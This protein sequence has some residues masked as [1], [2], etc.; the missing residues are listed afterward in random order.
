MKRLKALIKLEAMPA[1][2]VGIY[3]LIVNLGAIMQQRNTINTIWN[4]YLKC[5]IVKAFNEYYYI[6][7]YSRVFYTPIVM[8]VILHL[9]G[10]GTLVLLSFK[11]DK[12]IETGRFLKSLPY[13]IKER[14]F[15]KVSIGLLTYTVTYLVYVVGSYFSAAS[16]V[17]KYDEIFKVTTLAAIK[18][19]IFAIERVFAPILLAYLIVVAA[20]LFLTMLQYAV[21]HLAGGMIIGVLTL[22]SPFFILFSGYICLKNEQINHILDKI[23]VGLVNIVE[24]IPIYHMDKDTS[25]DMG[26]DYITYYPLRIAAILIGI[27]ITL[28]LIIYFSHK[29]RIEKEDIL[30]P[31]KVVQVIFI[32]GV[33][34]CSGLLMGDLYRVFVYGLFMYSSIDI[35]YMIMA[36][37]CVIGGIIS[38][39]IA[40]IG[41]KIKQGGRA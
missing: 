16:M 11:N 26:Y 12:S 41:F 15:V 9:L 1:L 24:Y 27:L 28:G 39:K 7:M 19:E 33:T 22:I 25:Y 36:I 20:Y 13:T 38:Y 30:I 40:H 17:E 14:N 29:Q 21:N 37:G 3:L 35:G 6:D 10:I 34:I 31:N 2:F 4:E 23:A 18:N 5:G 8:L 32:I